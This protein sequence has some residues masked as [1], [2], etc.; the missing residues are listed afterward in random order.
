MRLIRTG[1]REIRGY[2]GV[3]LW[4]W[5]GCFCHTSMFQLRDPVLV[6]QISQL[7]DPNFWS[8]FCL[9]DN[10][11]RLF[12]IEFYVSSWKSIKLALPKL[13]SKG[14]EFYYSKVY[15]YCYSHNERK[16]KY[17]FRYIEG[18]HLISN[19]HSRLRVWTIQR[20]VMPLSQIVCLQSI[21][22][23]YLPLGSMGPILTLSK[24]FLGKRFALKPWDKGV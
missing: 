10:C 23:L 20:T 24:F 1:P 9:K 7:V 17:V 22:S 21:W 13:K 4:T 12:G 11:V 19:D 18:C 2:L 15:S 14:V 8:F 3:K 5:R 6:L 16:G